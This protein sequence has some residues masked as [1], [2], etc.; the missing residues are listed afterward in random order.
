MCPQKA[1]PKNDKFSH[2]AKHRFLKINFVATPLLTKNVCV[3][4]FFKVVCFETKSIHV[5]QK[6]NF[7]ISKNNK[8]KRRDLNEKARQ[9]TKEKEKTLMKTIAITCFDVIPFMKQKQRRNKRKER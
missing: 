4:V 8:D 1:P 5:E 3:C 6:H 2:F 9:E 7:K